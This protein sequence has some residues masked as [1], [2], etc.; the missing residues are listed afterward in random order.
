MPDGDRRRDRGR[1]SPGPRR[2]APS[3]SSSPIEPH[4]AIG[5]LDEDE[6][7]VLRSLT[8]VP[9]HAP[10]GRPA[11]GL[12]VKQIRHQ[13]RLGGGF[14]G[15]AECCSRTWG[16]PGA[17]HPPAGPARNDPRRSSSPPD[18]PRPDDTF[19]LRRRRG[20]AAHQDHHVVGNTGPYATHGFTV[21]S[22]SGSVLAVQLPGQTLHR[23]RRLHQPAGGRGVPMVRA[24]QALFALE[25][26]HGR[27]RPAWGCLR[28]PS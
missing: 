18:P 21:Q 5:W 22:V 11:L 23:R 24:P 1:G 8:Q 3:R 26:P 4:I 19:R 16:P 10:D 13:A 12:P 25:S 2:P 17:G 27:H 15:Q 7:L 9:F 20:P 6:R 28:P 14:G